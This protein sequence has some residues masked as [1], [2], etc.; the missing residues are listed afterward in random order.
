MTKEKLIE[1]IEK[2]SVLE[3]SELVEALE[4]KFGVTA[5]VP[6]AAM[7]G[8]AAAAPAE[9]KTEFDVVLKGFDDK[10]KIGVIK[11]VREVMQLGLKE[12]KEFVESSASEPQAVKEGLPKKDADELKKKLEDAG[13]TVEL[14]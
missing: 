9:E 13:A 1:E 7:A 2:M 12:S 6:M 4:E 10:K 5:A 11:V 3:L 8:P 14:K